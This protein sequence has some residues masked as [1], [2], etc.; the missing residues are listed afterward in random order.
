MC[1]RYYIEPDV[2]DIRFREA[3][4]A[5]N[6]KNLT[7][8]VKT[9]GEIFPSDRVPVIAP[10]RSLR[11]SAFAMTWGYRLRGGKRV[12]NARSENAD[13]TPLFRDGFARRRCVV[14]ASYYFEWR[15][16]GR[17][18]V[19]YAIAP[20]GPSALYM[21]GIYTIRDEEPEFAILTR[22]ASESVSFIHDRMPVILPDAMIERWLNPEAIPADIL[23]AAVSDMCPRS[24][25][26]AQIGMDEI[27]GINGAKMIKNNQPQT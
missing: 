21:A 18:A 16:S 26:P 3:L 25:E 6:R 8:P 12:I 13:R 20:P 7:V 5:L 2:D 14:P 4:D 22:G 10:D 19:K 9:E 1:G 23:T 11:V 15:K 17:E 24:A 27:T